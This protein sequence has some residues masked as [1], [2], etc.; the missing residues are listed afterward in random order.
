MKKVRIVVEFE[1]GSR[2]HQMLEELKTERGHRTNPPVIIE[3]L[4]TLHR[5]CFPGGYYGSKKPRGDVDAEEEQEQKFMDQ[6]ETQEKRTEALAKV[7]E[8]KLKAIAY[9]L[10]GE[11]IE[12]SPG[13]FVVKYYQYS[14][15][16]R[17][18]VT[19]PLSMMD[20][21][22]VRKQYYPNKEEVLALQAEGKVNYSLE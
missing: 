9:E 14:E 2:P 8:N 16:N 20:E 6:A 15:R 18:Q 1:P 21:G 7:R 22:L 17:N 5:K 3:A 10:K 12:K 19:I 4:A 13:N 11:I